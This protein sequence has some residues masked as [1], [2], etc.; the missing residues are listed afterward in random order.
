MYRLYHFTL[1]PFCRKV[2]LVLAEKKIETELVHEKYWEKSIDFL[3]KNPAG[4]VPIL[5]INELILSD[6]QTICEYLEET[7]EKHHLMPEEALERAEVRRLVNWFD[8]KF[9]HEVTL[10][11]LFERITKKIVGQGHPD[12]QNIKKGSQN[13]KVHLDYMDHLLDSRSWLAGKTLTL[14]D[15]TAASHLSCL[16]YISD[17]DWSRSTNVKGWYAKIKSRPAFRTILADQISGFPPPRHYTDL[18]F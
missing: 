11:L 18:D 4:K 1:S 17:V 13:I 14:A 12:G 6:S 15:F 3:K 16:D 9:Y 5:K 7:G 10:K 2:R 8:D